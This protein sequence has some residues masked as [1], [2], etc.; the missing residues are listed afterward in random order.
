MSC[1]SGNE[2]DLILI[3]GTVW[4]V[5]DQQPEAEAVAIV[6]NEIAAVGSTEEISQWEGSGTQVVDLEGTFVVPGFNDNHVHFANAARFLEFNIMRTSSQEEFVERVE[7]V[8]GRLEDGE[9]IL[10]GLWGAYD[11][12]EFGSPGGGT[13]QRFTPDMSRVE[14]ITQNN[15]VFIQR[16]DRSEYA[17]NRKAMEEAGLDPDNPQAEGLEFERD[18]NG[19]PTGIVTGEVY[20]FFSEFIPS[21]FSYERRVQ[22]TKNALAEMRK[23]GVTNVSDMSDDTQV[24]IYKDLKERGELTAR[25]HYRYHL[26]RWEEL[27]EQGMEIGSG[28]AWIRFGSLKGHID[29][30]MGNSSARFYE[31]YDHNPDERGSWRRLMVDEDGNYAPDKF[32]SYMQGA[33]E[34]GLQLTVHAIGDEANHLLLNMLEDLIEENGEKDRRFR[35]VH[36]QVMQDEDIARMGDLDVIAEVQPI[37]AS[38]DMRWMEERIGKDRSEGAYAFKSIKDSGAMLSFGTD[39]PGTA[40]AEYHISPMYGLYAAVTRKTM[41]G[42][43]EGGWFPEERISMEEAIKAYT[44][45]TAYANFEDDIKGSITVGKLAD[46]TVLDQNLFEVDPMNLP[47][48]NVLYTIVDGEIV[49]KR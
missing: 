29:G 34:A 24:E 39:W 45:N 5:D 27:A 17:I 3:N 13:G 16:F 30:I 31:P 6:D 11:D 42:E 7:D 44:L 4:T 48:V 15:P 1:N 33:D 26:E 20:S 36:A 18:G 10:G 46:I 47:D 21:D 35:L 19:N 2:A 43:P 38:D 9:W 41:T 25:I 40:A 37:H 32:Y 12:W 8:V 49:Y 23:Y 14:E 28:D 22:Q